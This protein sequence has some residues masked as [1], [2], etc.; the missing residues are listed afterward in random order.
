MISFP[1]YIVIFILLMKVVILYYNPTCWPTCLGVFASHGSRPF[2]WW[3][4]G[5]TILVLMSTLHSKSFSS[6]N[7]TCNGVFSLNKPQISQYLMHVL[8]LLYS[9]LWRVE[10]IVKKI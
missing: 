6:N 10:T 4:L 5:H 8:V 9:F 2:G 7:S 3:L 1:K